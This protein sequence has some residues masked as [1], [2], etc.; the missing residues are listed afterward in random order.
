M[1]FEGVLCPW[2]FGPLHLIVYD[3]PVKLEVAT[4]SQAQ[5]P[6]ENSDE[7]SANGW[8]IAAAPNLLE[9][10]EVIAAHALGSMKGDEDAERTFAIIHE[11]AMLA[12]A[13]AKPVTKSARLPRWRTDKDLLTWLES[14]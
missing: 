13:K 3:A 2:V 10:L 14:L 4:I 5:E 1:S 11:I 9:G 12:I 8:L 7:T 6:T